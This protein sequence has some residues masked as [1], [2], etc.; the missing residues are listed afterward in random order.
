MLETGFA[1]LVETDSGGLH[2]HAGTSL[3]ARLNLAGAMTA[4][5]SGSHSKADRICRQRVWP[6]TRTDCSRP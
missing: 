4:C 6:G 3:Y 5:N 2:L 1:G